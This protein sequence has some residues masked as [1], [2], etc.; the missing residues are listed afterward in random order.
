MAQTGK[1]K[2]EL[3]LRS[4][5]WGL[6]FDQD[7]LHVTAIQNKLNQIRFTGNETIEGY[8]EKKEE[9]MLEF[10]EDFQ[11]K[12][13]VKRADAYLVIP[14]YQASVQIVDFPLEAKDNLEEVMEYQLGNY[15]PGDLEPWE[16]FPQILSKTDQL[17]VMI[18]AVKK[19]HLGHAFGFIRRWNLKLAGVTLDTL[20]IVNALGRTEGERHGQLRTMLL[21]FHK[22][23]MEMA[24]INQGR[25]VSSM[26]FLYP[27]E[28]KPQALMRHLENGFAISRIDPN[29]FDQFI[30]SGT[31]P[32]PLAEFLTGEL[33]LPRDVWVDA[34]GDPVSPT[35]MSS[36]GAAVTGVLDKPS[37]GLNML[38][39]KLRK[40]H[41]RLPVILGTVALILAGIIFLGLEIKEYSGLVR[42]NNRAQ[43][44]LEDIQGRMNELSEARFRYDT[45]KEESDLFLRYQTPYLLSKLLF[46]LSQD[47][48]DDTY[49]ISLQIRRGTELKIQGESGSPYDVERILDGIPFI[50]DVK[51]GNAITSGRN[52]DD[53]KKFMINAKI[54]LEGLR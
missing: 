19:E 3:N 47:L 18:V 50:D 9:E 37:L 13:H 42:E 48:P 30:W 21:N 24:A 25:L 11:A 52:S 16:F 40:R 43:V 36:F 39:E 53:K 26:Y 14:R 6:S 34:A 38:P 28:E 23:G 8:E 10:L 7:R 2:L 12:F 29:D 27:P 32:E 15:F 45:V 54:K 31:A 22:N 51:S 41:K 44:R 20:A 4:K 17:R 1:L 49:L 35:A 5:G 33:N 46:N